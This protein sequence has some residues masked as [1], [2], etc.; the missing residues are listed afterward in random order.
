ML[1][2][3]NANG[4]IDVSSKEE[5][6]RFFGNRNNCLGKG[7]STEFDSRKKPIYLLIAS[8]NVLLEPRADFVVRQQT[9]A[10]D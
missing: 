8:F 3:V 10:V 6:P 1:T 4:P 9:A 2:R 5:T 7:N